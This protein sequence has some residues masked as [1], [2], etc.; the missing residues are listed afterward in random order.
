MGRLL[1]S[2]HNTPNTTL[3]VIWH[4]GKDW[5][6]L[7][8]RAAKLHG[9][10]KVLKSAQAERSREVLA[11]S[12]HVR[13]HSADVTLS[14]E[15]R[16]DEMFI[17]CLRDRHNL[18]ARLDV[19]EITPIALGG[20]HQSQRLMDL[21][22]STKKHAVFILDDDRWGRA[23]VRRNPSLSAVPVLF[24]EPNFAALLD[25]DKIYAH[26]ERFSGLS[27][28]ATTDGDERWF[29][30]LEMAVLKRPGIYDTERGPALI[31][32]YLDLSKYEAFVARLKEKI[33]TLFPGGESPS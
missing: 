32:E 11:P 25:L 3:P 26:R 20:M 7:F 24:L 21:L 18:A 30:Y 13:R 33:D 9:A 29:H 6:P 19:K 31:E 17:D 27:E 1:V 22:K 23:A 15:G 16:M 5:I 4:S 8:P 10:A 12:M 14:V 28:R 2:D